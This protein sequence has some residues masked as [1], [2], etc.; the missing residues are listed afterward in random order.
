MDG[1]EKWMYY[2][3]TGSLYTHYSSSAFTFEPGLNIRIIPLNI[4]V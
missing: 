3:S 2:E 1:W 4:I